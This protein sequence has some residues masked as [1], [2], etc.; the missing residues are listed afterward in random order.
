MLITLAY[1]QD[2][3]NY[4]GVRGDAGDSVEVDD[5][6]GIRIVQDGWARIPD[7]VVRLNADQVILAAQLEGVDLSNAATATQRKAALA[8]AHKQ[9]KE[10]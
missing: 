9:N 3:Q 10:G 7:S 6:V 2:G 5:A 4:P 8:A 1:P